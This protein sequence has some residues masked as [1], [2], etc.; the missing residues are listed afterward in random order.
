[1]LS[2]SDHVLPSSQTTTDLHRVSIRDCF[3]HWIDNVS[4]A[5]DIGVGFG[6]AFLSRLHPMRW[7]RDI[8]QVH[9]VSHLHR[10]RISR[11]GAVE[12]FRFGSPL[13]ESRESFSRFLSSVNSKSC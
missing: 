4:I 1:M 2:I 9:E 11:D 7:V 8:G 5:R 12:V 10:G 13:T 6:Q 3:S